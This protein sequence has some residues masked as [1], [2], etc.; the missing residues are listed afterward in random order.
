MPDR[1]VLPARVERLQHDEQTVA[2]VGI[3]QMLQ[4]AQFPEVLL[5]EV[6]TLLDPERFAGIALAEARLLAGLDDEVLS[7]IHG[8]HCNSVGRVLL[9][10]CVMPPA[11]FAG[12][13]A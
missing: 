10:D 13:R 9:A 8:S 11:R 3:Q 1:A 6:F 2:F 7:D 5:H 4:L 12:I